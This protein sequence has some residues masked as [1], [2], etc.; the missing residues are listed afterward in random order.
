MAAF[1]LATLAFIALARAS[2]AWGSSQTKPLSSAISS[3]FPPGEPLTSEILA[4]FLQ[5]SEA[6]IAR[7]SYVYRDGTSLRLLGDHWTASGA[8]VYWLGLDENVVPP[9]GQPFYAPFN[10]S[11]PSKGRTVE[12]M[13]TLVTMG[14]K[15]IRSQTLGVSVGNPLSLMPALGV[16]NQQAFESIDWAVWQARQHGL[17]IIAP[18]TDDYNYYHGGKFSFLR[19]AGFNITGSESPLPPETMEFYTNTSIINDFKSYIQH[20][21]THVNPYTGLTY[22]QD[23]T[24]IGYETGNELSGLE[25]GDKDV[26]VEW[27][28]EI[29]Q[30]IKK[31]G[32]HKLCIDGTYGVNTTHFAVSEV[33]IFSDHFYPLNTTLLNSDIAEV[34]SANRVY[35]AGEIDWTGLNGGKTLQGSSLADFYGTILSRQNMTRPVVAGSLFWSLFGHDVPNCEIYVDHADGYTMQYGNPT[36]TDTVDSKISLVR[37]HYF[38]MQNITVDSYLPA[39]ACPHNF[40]PGYDAEYTYY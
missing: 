18:L 27:T 40:I 22:A 36:N 1:T 4:T 15:L 30:F 7:S 13:A 39:V 17:R 16:Y 25:F 9:A 21:L 23:P 20:L 38:A 5:P 8:N 31:L 34:E 35:L 14:A 28:R 3:V 10:A 6:D 33:D 11:Y 32:P 2:P 24:I 12:I 19:F 29:C 37:E 26:P